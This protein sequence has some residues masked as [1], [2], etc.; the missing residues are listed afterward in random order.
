MYINARLENRT[1]GELGLSFIPAAAYN[2][3]TE[4]TITLNFLDT[5]NTKPT[6][7]VLCIYKMYM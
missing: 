5:L 6:F 4:I 3:I 2:S 7:L 1:A